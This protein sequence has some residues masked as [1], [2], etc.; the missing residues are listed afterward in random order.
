MGFNQYGLTSKALC[1]GERTKGGLFRP[2][3]RTIR[4][5]QITGALRAWFGVELHAVGHLAEKD[6]HNQSNTFTYAPRDRGQGISKVPLIVEFLADVVGEVYILD[7]TGILPESFEIEMGAL[8][9]QGLGRCRL[10]FEGPAPNGV[11]R[12]RLNTRLPLRLVDIFGVERVIVPVYGYLFRPL[13]QITGEYELSLF[14][15]SEIVGPAFLLQEE[16]NG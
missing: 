7:E 12:G 5:S 2:T 9:S 4:Y 15:G 6:G 3:C 11:K 10:T 13:S 16:T 8:R 14:E 1:L